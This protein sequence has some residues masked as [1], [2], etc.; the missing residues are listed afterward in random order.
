MQVNLQ[1]KLTLI[2]VSFTA[3]ATMYLVFITILVAPYSVSDLE[4]KM[5]LY[6]RIIDETQVG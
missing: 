6:L 5:A 4:H 1:K 3:F 2:W